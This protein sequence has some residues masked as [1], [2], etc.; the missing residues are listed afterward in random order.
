MA[1]IEVDG[2]CVDFPLYHGNAR[3]LKRTF[4]SA[5]SGG[6]LNQDAKS[7]VVVEALRDVSFSLQPGDRLGLVGGNGAGK[8]TLLRTIAGIYEP[9]RGRVRV[10]GSLNALLDP[11][12]GMNSDLT[13]RENIMLRGMYAGLSRK[14]CRLLEE[15][16]QNFADL[17]DFM[18]LPVR[19]Y[20][21]GMTVRLGFALATAIRPQLLLMDEWFL[22][23]DFN[24]MQKARGRIENM[25]R[26]AEIL[27]LSSHAHGVV[28]AWC[29]KVIWMDQGRVRA[30]GETAAILEQYVGHPVAPAEDSLS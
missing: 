3:S 22:A 17:D 27:V 18:D 14:Q 21:S 16:V 1:L 26:G 29:T 15:D 11:G 7:R 8:T 10:Q 6:R 12:L 5:A 4:V 24:F 25:V 28:A 30:A 19:I 20:S 9:V 2:V 13:G 23:G